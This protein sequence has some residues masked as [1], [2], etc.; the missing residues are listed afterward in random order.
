MDFLEVACRQ[1]M[2]RVVAVRHYRKNN[3]LAIVT[4]HPMPEGEVTFHAIHNVVSDF[5]IHE[6]RIVFMDI[7]L[8]HL[9]QAYVRFKNAFDRDQLI[10]LGAI[11][12]GN[13]S[14]TFVELNKGRN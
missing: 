3:D 1:T 10:Q 2:G 4:I 8:T 12:F 5:L 9:G 7:Q 13:I 14:L 11:P 6:W